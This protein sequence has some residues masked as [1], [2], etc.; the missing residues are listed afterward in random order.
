M[1]SVSFDSVWFVVKDG[2][3]FCLHIG[4]SVLFACSSLY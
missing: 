1:M 3:L 2:K 4:G